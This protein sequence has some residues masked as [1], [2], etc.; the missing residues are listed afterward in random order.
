MI[1]VQSSSLVPA[2]RKEQEP[3]MVTFNFACLTTGGEAAAG[4]EKMRGRAQEP[5]FVVCRGVSGSPGRRIVEQPPAK[6]GQRV[7]AAAD[8]PEAAVAASVQSEGTFNSTY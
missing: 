4:A 7:G 1:Q 5:H 8:R 6:R 2:N 3:S